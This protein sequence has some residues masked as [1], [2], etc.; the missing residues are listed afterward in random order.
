MATGNAS[1]ISSCDAS[2]AQ[3]DMS[4]L[5]NTQAPV[6][7]LSDRSLVRSPQTGYHFNLFLVKTLS[8]YKLMI[9]GSMG[10]TLHFLVVQGTR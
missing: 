10:P 3:T 1:L 9:V 6:N 5:T 2:A 7:L 4:V 8:Q